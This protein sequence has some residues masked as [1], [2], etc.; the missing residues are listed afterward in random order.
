MQEWFGNMKFFWIWK[1]EQFGLEMAPIFVGTGQRRKTQAIGSDIFP[2]K[3]VSV[4][5][6]SSL[7]EK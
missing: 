7:G 6:K 1:N 5:Q 4:K 3:K 2:L